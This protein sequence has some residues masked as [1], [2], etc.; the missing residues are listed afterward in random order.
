MRKGFD[1]KTSSFDHQGD[2][3]DCSEAK[4]SELL[5]AISQAAIQMPDMI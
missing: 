4:R 2:F 5:H 1:D 3:L